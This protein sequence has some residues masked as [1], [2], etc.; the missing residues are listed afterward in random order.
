[1]SVAGLFSDWNLV[2]AV[3]LATGAAAFILHLVRLVRPGMR[4]GRWPE[5]LLA[6]TAALLALSLL[7][8]ASR[9]L[10]ADLSYEYVWIYTRTDLPLRYRLAGTWTGRE[11]SLLL[12]STYLAIVAAV[13]AWWH[14]RDA[15]GDGD[16][17]AAGNDGPDG[18][19]V[20]PGAADAELS[21]ARLWTD[22]WLSGLLVAFLAATWVQDTFAPTPE[23]FLRGRPDGNGLNPTL[24]SPFMLIHPPL[25][26][27]AYALASVPAAAVLGHL[28][29]GTDRWSQIA[30]LPSRIDWLLYTF[31]MG[32]GG[33]W[34]YYT[35]GFGGYWAWDP[36]EVANFLPWLALT[37]YLHAQRHHLRHGSYT[38]IG[39]FLG[40]LPFLLTIFSTLS[41]RSGLWV[42]VH[43]FTDPTQTFN[44]DAA[45]RFLDI[46]QAEPMLRFFVAIFA[47]TLLL[48][49]A[50]WTR[51]L[52]I[53]HGTLKRT[54]RIVAGLFGAA[55]AYAVVA[56]Q[57]FTSALFEM[58]HVASG[59][60]T[61]FGLLG[62]TVL[63]VLLATAPV[64]VAPE[65][66]A[67]KRRG[68]AIINT[69]NLVYTS[70]TLLGLSLLL[71]FLF[72]MTAVNGWDR[73]FWD[74]RV[75]WI[76]T[77]IALALIVLM[78]YQDM[79]RRNGLVLAGAALFAAAGAYV[80]RRSSESGLAALGAYSLTLSLVVLA[81]AVYKLYHVH[82]RAKPTRV[83][84]AGLLLWLGALLDLLFWVN[85]PSRLGLPGL[86]W[87]WGWPVQLLLGGVSLYA[88]WG[89]HRIW[90]G[91]PPRRPWH[92]HL[93]VGLLG[94][95]Y[96]APVL[97][98]VAFFF[99]R[100]HDP[101]GTSKARGATTI[102]WKR[103]R[104]PAIYGIHFLVAL[105]FVGYT[106]STYY[107]DQTQ[108]EMAVG[109][110]TDVGPYA[111]EA[112]A[113]TA[114]AEAGTPWAARIHPDFR[115]EK[116]GESRGSV[117]GIL[118]W[119]PQTGSHYPLPNTLRTWTGDIYVSVFAVCTDPSG[120]CTA[121]TDWVSAFQPTARV[122]ADAD[123]TA[124]RVQVHHL[125]A[126]G[127]LWVALVAFPGYMV[128]LAAADRHRSAP[129]TNPI[130]RHGS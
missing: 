60:R 14:R 121:A 128:L 70:V 54:G 69:R 7:Y 79:G 94:A 119:E 44:P 116:D 114:V 86:W 42:S 84:I 101:Q 51:R 30:F 67:P 110:A 8:L 3:A 65:K 97:A 35:L 55:A 76:A 83:R 53:E 25:M 6:A 50:L 15:R 89:A 57:S 40:L 63:A 102:Q 2:L 122:S 74:A 36:V 22:L 61:G 10:V 31:A 27:L 26:F 17:G 34:A 124:V 16:D 92:V 9:F 81:A 28:A 123:I 115:V 37:V 20:P 75:P 109:E 105:V 130:P 72:H 5:R 80:M 77:P 104:V 108:E 29:S 62:L 24:L 52:A 120:D 68:L 39:P 45:G 126:V 33:L 82:A 56:P 64:F 113:A 99:H 48:G 106:L 129:A 91:D 78:T 43:A 58:A 13:M 11:G 18:E 23:F 32:L 1:M 73:A 111:V 38:V 88:L 117:H 41:T 4:V 21:R 125:P 59:G 95:F 90:A 118:Y 85:P 112:G 46:L 103:L 127:T 98:A 47:G 49:L 19:A 71:A 96:V 93:L 107:A 12:W 100:R 87:H 66:E